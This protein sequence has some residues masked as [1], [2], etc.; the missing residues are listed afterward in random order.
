MQ[1]STCALLYMLCQNGIPK[2]K[3][4]LAHQYTEIRAVTYKARMRRWSVS[5]TV[6][7]KCKMMETLFIMIEET[8]AQAS[9][10]ALW[11]WQW[12]RGHIRLCDDCGNGCMTDDCPY[13]HHVT[14][15]A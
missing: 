4:S 9:T 8:D 14:T 6:Q 5:G 12:W 13:L 15:S 11:S 2:S 10:S 3:V 7:G 1:I